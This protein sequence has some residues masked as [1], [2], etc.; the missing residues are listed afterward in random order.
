MNC[1]KCGAELSDGVIFCKECGYRVPQETKFRI[2][3][4]CG[5]KLEDNAKFCSSCGSKVEYD[6]EQFLH[7]VDDEDF[8]APSGTFGDKLK[9]SVKKIWRKL[10]K[11]TQ[12]YVIALC[13]CVFALLIAIVADK[14]VPVIAS[15]AQIIALCALCAT[16]LRII[17][18]DKKWIS[19]VSAVVIVLM[20]PT[21]ISG[22][23][24][25]KVK[26]N[27]TI[28]NLETQPII[29]TTSY[30]LRDD[31]V[32]I[33]FSRYDLTGKHYDD[34]TYMLQSLGFSNI[35]YR[36]KYDV[37]YGFLYQEGDVFDVSIAGLTDFKNG[38]IF[39]KDAPV[40]VTYHASAE[41]DPNKKVEA[42]TS[43][44]VNSTSGTETQS[45]TNDGTTS[46]ISTQPADDQNITRGMKN[47]LRSAKNYLI[48]MAFSR[49]GLIEQL[50]F[51]GYSNNE[52]VYAVDNCDA[53]W[54]EQ[55]VRSAKQYLSSMSFSRQ[56]LIEQLEFEG[57]T[58]DEAVYGVD[59]VY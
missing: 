32:Q 39:K 10:D 42:Q 50:E 14:T 35:D 43:T 6:E 13:V 58:H 48:F 21:Y 49:K 55:A 33:N 24:A 29:E 36:I 7:D 26:S 53:D 41:S 23:G 45:D 40:F 12:I 56:G 16:H 9:N 17:K 27:E 5:A 1:P 3:R 4:E 52:A 2:C 11:T 54:N 46:T 8:D 47:A 37:I 20:I 38:D 18:T 19:W 34:V 59:Q 25:G 22:L 15:V 51:E 28:D 30:V 57:F 44:G 31:E